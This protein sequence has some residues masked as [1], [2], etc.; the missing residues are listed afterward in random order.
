MSVITIQ[1]RLQAQEETLRHLWIMMVEQNTLLV[2]QILEHIKSHPELDLWLERGYISDE[3]IKEIVKNLKQ[4]PKYHRMP[5]RFSN[6]AET[7]VKEIYKSWFAVQRMKKNLLWGKTRW[8]TMLKSE[9]ELLEQTG[10]T[11]PQLQAEAE[12]ILNREQKKFDKLKQNKDSETETP[13]DLFAHFFQV[14]DRVTK[15]YEKEKKP[16][17]KTKKLIK[18]CSVVYLLKN[19][20]SISIE[21]EDPEKYKQYRLKKEIQLDRLEEQLKARLPQGRNLAKEE[22]LEAL[23]Q[24]QCLITENEEMELL[25][26]RLLRSEKSIPFPVSYNTNTDICWSKNERGRICMTFN[27]MVTEGHTFEVFCHHRQLHWFQRFY[28]DYQLYKQ[29]KKQIPAGLITLRS[30]S[31]V[32]QEGETKKSPKP[33]LTNHLYLH[34]SVE[35]ELWTQEGTER[36]RQLKIAKTQQKIA[37]WLEQKSLNKNQQ[38]KLLANQTSLSLLENFKDFNRPS[39]YKP[40]QNPSIAM[41]VC[42]GLKEPVTVAV[43][44]LANGDVI[45]CHNTKQLLSK[46][47]QQKPKTGKQA[48]KHTPYDLFLRRRQQQQD[49]DAKRQHAQTKFADNRF[50]ESELGIYV[51]RLLAKAIIEMAIQYQVSSIVLPDLTN[52][53]EILNSELQARAEAKIPGCKKAQKQ[54][55]KKYRKSIHHWSYARLCYAIASKATQKGIAIEIERQIPSGTPEIQARDLALTAYCNRQQATG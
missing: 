35:T 22:Y 43:V 48:K 13:K 24:A 2:S 36:I 54:Y 37:R 47:I 44:N 9:Q 10:L 52:I 26:A 29:N 19:K 50:G 34:C 23:E 21:S 15:N 12:K 45:A 16:H 11:L 33:W 20:C 3:T 30:A 38:Q 1:C 17:L 55:A 32:W 25:Q 4:Q 41:G 5:G 53:R 40:Q 51:D 8:L 39:K 6:S 18:Q 27:G 46:P 14:Y 31:L 42:I 28:E 49:N 7:L